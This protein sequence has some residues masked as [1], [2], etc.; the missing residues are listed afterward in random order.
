MVYR[1]SS[2]NT[3]LRIT[4]LCT[5]FIDKLRNSLDT[6][7]SL[8]SPRDLH[9]AKLF[10]IKATQTAHFSH[11]IKL[12]I[13]GSL[14]PRSHA[15]S[16]LTAFIDKEGVVRVGGR[17]DEA[18]LNYEERHPAILPSSPLPNLIIDQ[19]Y[20]VT[21]HGGTQLTLSRVRQTTWIIGGRAPVK[22]YVLKC[23]V[24]AQQR[25]AQAQQLMSQLPLA[26]V[27]PSRPFSHAGVDYAGPIT[28]KT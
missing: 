2:L 19:A 18:Q 8:I 9:Q 26:R 11:E 23:V 5:R 14:L 16:R 15:F 25:G 6:S 27:T 21:L 17:L 10:W 24:C 20:R 4:A 12:L 3:L 22:S 7:P 13:K 28:L 1:Y